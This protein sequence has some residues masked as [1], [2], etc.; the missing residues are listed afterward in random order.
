MFVCAAVAYP[1]PVFVFRFNGDKIVF[2]SSKH[3]IVTSS[4]HGTLTVL[5][6]QRSDEGIYTCSA[7]NRYGSMST[8]AALSVQGKFGY[9]HC[10]SQVL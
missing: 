7:S 10:I 2:N 9:V 8:A 6:L 1:H 5:N 4:T 3:T